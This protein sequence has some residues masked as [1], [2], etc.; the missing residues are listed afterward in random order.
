MEKPIY[1]K[2]DQDKPRLS[3]VPPGIIEAVGIIRTYGTKKYKDPEG[4]RN[5]ESERYKDAFMR[6]LVEWLRDGYA[7]D[8]ESGL[9]HL[10]HMACNLAFLIELEKMPKP[11]TTDFQC[12][13]CGQDVGNWELFCQRCQNKWGKGEGTD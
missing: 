11:K 8:E 6:H 10:W 1:Y 5:V 13:I 12:R 4:W 9:P 7:V 3:L 2:F